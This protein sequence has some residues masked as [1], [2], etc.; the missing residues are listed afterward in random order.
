MRGIKRRDPQGEL[1]RFPFLNALKTPK[2]VGQDSEP[3]THNL[4]AEE[5]AALA[6]NSLFV[7]PNFCLQQRWN[8]NVGH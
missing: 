6:E 5:E 8:I 3:R 4:N 1:K 7:L 2:Y